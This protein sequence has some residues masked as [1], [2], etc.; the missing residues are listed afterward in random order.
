MHP[1]TIRASGNRGIP[2]IENS[3]M[4]LQSVTS[5]DE[6]PL[7]RS[8]KVTGKT[9][10]LSRTTKLTIATRPVLFEL[11]KITSEQECGKG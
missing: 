5:V 4:S 3:M 8:T 2:Y 6:G 7:Q 1:E 11:A 9:R 10:I